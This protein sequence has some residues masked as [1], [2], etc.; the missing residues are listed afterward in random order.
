MIPISRK[1][2][3]NLL[4]VGAGAVVLTTGCGPAIVAATAKLEQGTAAPVAPSATSTVTIESTATATQVPSPTSTTEPT[5]TQERIE[6]TR[7]R[8]PENPVVIEGVVGPQ[9]DLIFEGKAKIDP[10]VGSIFYTAFLK[11][12][13]ESKPEKN[14]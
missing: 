6:A 11:A 7:T 5:V 3:L 8:S 1:E 13:V 2:F 12:L 14:I 10:E 4:G 9:D